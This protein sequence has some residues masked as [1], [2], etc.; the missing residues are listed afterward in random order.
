MDEIAP[1]IFV[2][3]RYR[4]ANIG[5][6]AT[7]RGFV[8]VDTPPYPADAREWRAQLLQRPP[9]RIRYVVNLDHHRDRVL[10]NMWLQAPV[11]AHDVTGEKLRGYGHVFPQLIV[12]AL[13]ARDPSA[14]A[15]LAK[16]RIVAPQIT[17]AERLTLFDGKRTVTI[18]H[19]PGPTPGALWVHC[20][21]AQVLFTGDSVVLG[22]HPWLAEADTKAWL[23]NLAALRRNRLRVRVLVPGRGPVGDKGSAEAIANYLRLVR[24]RVRGLLQSGRPRTDTSTLVSELL[25]RYPISNES[26]ERVQRRVR[27]GLDHVYDELK[28]TGDES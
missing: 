17:I 18:M 12:D 2:E 22:T 6:I 16:V 15:E 8:C 21:E 27:A 26:R 28:T 3:T 4:G 10:G 23:D 11:I 14:A 1:G 20:P 24:G 25:R 19:M 7:D 13:S 9:G 5:A